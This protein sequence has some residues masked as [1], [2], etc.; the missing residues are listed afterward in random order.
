[1]LTY[2]LAT[3]VGLSLG[4]LGSG[5]SILAVPILK[6]VAHLSARE[7]VATSLATVGAVSLVGTILAARE[8]RVLWR[9]GLLFAAMAT[10][11]TFLGVE[12][13]QLLS[14]KAQM[15]AFVLVMGY[16][17]VRMF[18]SGESR[19]ES[20][21]ES[22]L[23]SAIAKALAVGILT[24]VVG[25]GGGF[26]IVPALVA[27][28]GLPMKKATGT[29]L[30]VITINSI[31]GTISY[32]QSVSLDWLFTLKFVLAA[33]TGLVFGIQW[34]KSVPE[35]RLKRVFAY[36]LAVVCVYTGVSEF[37]F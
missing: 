6:Y 29:S 10:V 17:V 37:L 30:L 27:L 21:P 36:L 16:A 5:G 12:L 14:E 32:S 3:L 18:S 34:S 33:V 35:K 13:A 11:G 15:G 4:L 23:L 24:G 22:G 1:M 2:L 25:V 31:V 7:A 19:Q 26:L 20:E 9:Q 28:F 8:K